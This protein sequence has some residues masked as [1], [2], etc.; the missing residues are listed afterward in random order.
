[1][2]NAAPTA[3]DEVVDVKDDLVDDKKDERSFNWVLLL[4]AFPYMQFF[5]LHMRTVEG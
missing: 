1:M 2:L 4:Q 3:S 5:L